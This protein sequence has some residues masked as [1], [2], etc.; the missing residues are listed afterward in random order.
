MDEAKPTVRKRDRPWLRSLRPLLWWAALVLVLFAIHKHQQLM[1]RT[2]LRFSVSL[3][4]QPLSFELIPTLDGLPISS[5]W[6]L[7]LGSHKFSIAHSKVEPFSTNLFI[8]YGEQNL[9]DISLKRAKGTLTIRSE[10]PAARIT[11]RGP[12]F[13]A[14][15]TNSASTTLS[16]PTD[17]YV[18]EAEYPHWR[19][20]GEVSVFMT[21]PGSWN[22]TPRLGTMRLACNRLGASFQLLK[23][24]NEL[25]EGGDFPSTVQDV[26]QGNYR[27]VAWHHGNRRDEAL[28]VKAAVTNSM[29]VQIEYGTAVLETEPVGATVATKN[30]RECGTTPL[31]LAELTPGRWQFLLRREGYEAAAVSLEIS[32]QQTNAFRTNLVSVSYGRAIAAARQYLAAADY[33]RALEAA[34]DALLAKPSDTEAVATKKEC[35]GRKSLRQAE[36]LGKQG[37]YIAAV[38][39]LESALQS[40]PESGEVKELMAD[41][42]KHE[43]EQIERMKRE[44]LEH[45]KKV[46]DSVLTNSNDATLFDLQELKTSKRVS[47]IQA[48]ILSTLKNGQPIFT[49]VRVISSEPEVFAIEAVQQLSTVLATSAGRRQCII[50]C[51]QTRDDET[52]ILFKVLEYKS[53]AVNKFSIGAWIG[54]PVEVNYVPVHQSRMEMTDKLQARVKEGIQIVTERIKVAIG[55]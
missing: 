53:V 52:Q 32:A 14:T 29:E 31:T 51:G 8:W 15:L 12:E 45:P 13:E 35:L 3:E 24:D 33:D 48:L 47:E 1:E 30:G 27:L 23:G 2:R 25:V 7:S 54:T 37:D 55:Q 49:D 40:L 10:P 38:K 9:G 34:T 11:I 20:A 18:V 5:G 26:P 6:R 4:G 17:R 44:R 22:F 41:F 19:E 39:E 36:K 43:P 46:F 28:T 16:V 50:V 42:K 21:T